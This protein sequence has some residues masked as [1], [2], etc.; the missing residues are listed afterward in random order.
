MAHGLGLPMMSLRLACED[1]GL[2]PGIAGLFAPWIVS[3]TMP[4]IMSD[5]LA[6]HLPYLLQMI[7]KA[8]LRGPPRARFVRVPTRFLPPGLEVQARFGSRLLEFLPLS[9]N[10]DLLL[11]KKPR[12]LQGAPS[13]VKIFP[14]RPR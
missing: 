14:R 13:D 3:C 1:V 8:L 7:H 12:G 2:L 5:H 6:V 9:P 10:S 11:A 4:P